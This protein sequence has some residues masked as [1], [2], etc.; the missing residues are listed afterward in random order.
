MNIY[1][2]DILHMIPLALALATLKWTWQHLLSIYFSIL[3]S[4]LFVELC[5]AHVCVRFCFSREKTRNHAVLC[6]NRWTFFSFFQKEFNEHNTNN[7]LK[8]LKLLPN[9]PRF[10]RI[11]RGRKLRLDE[12]LSVHALRLFGCQLY[13][14]NFPSLSMRTLC[15]IRLP[16]GLEIVSSHWAHSHSRH[17]QKHTHNR[18]WRLIGIYIL[19]FFLNQTYIDNK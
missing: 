9:L 4:Y 6:R 13:H 16:Y 15:S 18:L 14:D 5:L 17:C 11:L 3:L 2:D 1:T 8:S 12:G 19:F 10:E 7:W